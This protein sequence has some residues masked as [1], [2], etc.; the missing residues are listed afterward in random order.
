MYESCPH[1]RRRA[2]VATACTFCEKDIKETIQRYKLLVE[3]SDYSSCILAVG[4]DELGFK[5]F[6]DYPDGIKGIIKIS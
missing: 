1:C 3:L 6:G 5:L 2:E 4:F